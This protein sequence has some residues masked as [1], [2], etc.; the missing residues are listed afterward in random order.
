MVRSVAPLVV[1]TLLT[2]VILNAQSWL[3]ALAG[4]HATGFP[5]NWIIVVASAFWVGALV[6]VTQETFDRAGP[7]LRRSLRAAVQTWWPVLIFHLLGVL[8]IAIIG[9]LVMAVQKFGLPPHALDG[10]VGVGLRFVVNLTW[11]VVRCYGDYTLVVERLG[12]GNAFSNS[13]AA[14]WRQPKVCLVMALI[15]IAAAI[16]GSV[17]GRHL[18]TA[19]FVFWNTAITVVIYLYLATVRHRG[20][21]EAT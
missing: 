19:V 16:P 4:M 6:H 11:N 1:M 8:V 18:P 3:A 9:A 2:G 10:A 7:S 21:A 5:F 17:A 20:T 12:A 14:L 13:V 15:L